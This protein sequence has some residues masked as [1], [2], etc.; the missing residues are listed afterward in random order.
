METEDNEIYQFILPAP[1]QIA[2]TEKFNGRLENIVWVERIEDVFENPN[3]NPL[4]TDFVINI[5]N[6]QPKQEDMI[7]VY[8]TINMN[9][10]VETQTNYIFKSLDN[11]WKIE[12]SEKIFDVTEVN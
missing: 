3:L 2:I 12:T 5:G 10:S 4:P 9:G 11:E 1:L 8:V 6:L 7:T